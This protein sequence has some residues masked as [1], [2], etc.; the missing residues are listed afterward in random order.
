MLFWKWN[1]FCISSALWFVQGIYIFPIIP[2]KKWLFFQICHKFIHIICNNFPRKTSLFIRYILIKLPHFAN[3]TAKLPGFL[4]PKGINGFYTPIIYEFNLL[5]ILIFFIYQWVFGNVETDCIRDLP[6][7]NF[8]ILFFLLLRV[9]FIPFVQH[10]VCW[11]IPGLLEWQQV[12]EK[13]NW[14]LCRALKPIQHHVSMGTEPTDFWQAVLQFCFLVLKPW[15]KWIWIHDTLCYAQHRC[16]I[17][18][19]HL[20]WYRKLTFP[21]QE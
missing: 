21:P 7:P 20:L 17:Y 15:C 1:G 9:L 11:S 5:Y 19:L 13:H 3:S 10:F 6:P 12:K 14:K 18:L 2:K 16:L 8:Y 4:F